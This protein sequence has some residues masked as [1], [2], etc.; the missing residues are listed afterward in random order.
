MKL[1]HPKASAV[2][3]RK[4]APANIFAATLA[5]VYRR[6]EDVGVEAVIVT[7]LKLRDIERKIFCADLVECA[8]HATLE[9]RPEG[10]NRIRVDRADNVTMRGVVNGL[11]RIVD[12]AV[13]HSAFIGRQQT[14]F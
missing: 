6:S 1:H 8:N 9:D 4:S 11:A 2:A 7:E 12:Q 5:S 13:V 10:L 3:P 14:N